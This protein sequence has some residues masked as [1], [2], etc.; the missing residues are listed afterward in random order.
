MG[1][2]FIS[3][4]FALFVLGGVLSAVVDVGLMQAL[5]NNGASLVAA[6]SSGFLA[7]LAVNY[8][9]HAKVT[10]RQMHTASAVARYLC[11]V[12]INY[13]LTLAIVALAQY[14][15]G[16]A[17]LGKLLTLPVVAANGFLLSKF[18]VFKT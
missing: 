13:L 4:Q 3:A 17:L 7:G 1:K 6:T 12:A 8:A 18:W 14:L 5:L 11:V 15:V 2:H 9:F 10:F 16:S